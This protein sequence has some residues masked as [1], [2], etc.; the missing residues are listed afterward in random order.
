MKA[1]RHGLS[2]GVDRIDDEFF[3]S[4]KVVGKLTH[5]DYEKI[6]PILDAALEGVTEAEIRAYLDAS[7]MEGWE[8]RA[9][10]DDFKLGLKHGNQFAKIAIYGHSTWME[11][12]SK[13]GGWFISG[14]VE[15]FHDPDEA[16]AWLK[17]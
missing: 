4:L 17:E 13:I 7:E 10:W 14:E 16:I 15:F 3:L 6:N 12:L 1:K 11:Y 2:I 8:L 9:A 5:A